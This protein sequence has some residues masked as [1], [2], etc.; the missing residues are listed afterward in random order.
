MLSIVDEHIDLIGKIAMLT[1]MATIL[2]S[3]YEDIFGMGNRFIIN[4][5][6]ENKTMLIFINEKPVLKN[7]CMWFC[8]KEIGANTSGD[9][10]WLT[11]NQL[12]VCQ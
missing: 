8:L 9:W 3:E 11:L 10:H 2:E 4:R 12:I 5:L 6:Y 7:G 1:N